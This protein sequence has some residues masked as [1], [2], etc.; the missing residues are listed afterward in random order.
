V[1]LARRPRAQPTRAEHARVDT[2]DTGRWAGEYS[3]M[4]ASQSEWKGKARN[5]CAEKQALRT[6]LLLA[7]SVSLSF[8]LSLSLSSLSLSLPQV[9]DLDSVRVA[10]LKLSSCSAAGDHP[11][12]VVRRAARPCTASGQDVGSTTPLRGDSLLT[13][14]AGCDPGQARPSARDDSLQ[15]WALSSPR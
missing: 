13:G 15:Y 12:A 8:Y 4:V 6:G 3:S 7:L 1:A 2:R 9:T 11:R 5:C 14:V 10:P